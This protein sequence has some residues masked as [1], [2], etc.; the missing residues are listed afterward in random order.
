MAALV[1]EI[2]GTYEVCRSELVD[3]AGHS[4]STTVHDHGL[5][6]M[7]GPVIYVA[8]SGSDSNDGTTMS[9]PMATLVAA[10]SEAYAAPQTSILLR[11][12]ETRS[13]SDPIP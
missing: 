13:T 7:T 2:P 12:A 5:T 4:G 3:I 9:A 1:F 10:L 6:A 8:S 11:H